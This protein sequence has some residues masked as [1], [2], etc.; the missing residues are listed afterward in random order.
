[1]RLRAQSRT[2]TV[3]TNARTNRARTSRGRTKRTRTR[4]A[5]TISPPTLPRPAAARREVATPMPAMERQ[6]AEK[7]RAATALTRVTARIIRQTSRGR[8]DTEPGT[9]TAAPGAEVV[10]G[11]TPAGNSLS[12]NRFRLANKPSHMERRSTYP[13]PDIGVSPCPARGIRLGVGASDPAR[14]PVLLLDVGE[15]LNLLGL[16]AF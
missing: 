9:A 11:A 10:A 3:Q 2:R 1:M 15:Y 6:I 12:G 7:A 16:L 5:S 14:P 4:A 8:A 13:A